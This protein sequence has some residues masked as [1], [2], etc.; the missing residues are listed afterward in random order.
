MV[1]MFLQKTL[2]LGCVDGL[3]TRITR[4]M[5]QAMVMKE[6]RITFSTMLTLGRFILVPLIVGAMVQNWWGWAFALFVVAAVTDLL[7]G[8]LARLL[9]Q[10]TFLGACLDALADKVLILAVFTTLSCID[11]PLFRIPLWFLLLVLA[12][13]LVQIF[14]ALL[15]YGINGT[16][17]VKPTLLG[18]IA[19]IM[20][21]LFVVWLFAC[22]FFGWVPV[23]TYYA[24][25]AFLLVILLSSLFR[26][27]TIGLQ[28]LSI[29]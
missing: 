29:L 25:L 16:I 15:I 5:V 22:Y 2:L 9:H 27:I 12:K 3:M 28:Q 17:E 10:E 8:Y 6:R 26:Y 19:M 1:I 23:K 24:M 20:Q 21:S 4:A 7:D 14:G 18:K 11:A 13:E